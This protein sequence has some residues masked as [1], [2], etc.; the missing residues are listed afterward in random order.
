MPTF[1]CSYTLRLL[2]FLHHS[3]VVVCW[4][5]ANAVSLLVDTWTWEEHNSF[6]GR[7]KE[8]TGSL[9]DHSTNTM[10][11]T[12]AV[13]LFIFLCFLPGFGLWAAR[14]AWQVLCILFKLLIRCVTILTLPVDGSCTL[15]FT[16]AEVA[17]PSR[18]HLSLPSTLVRRGERETKLRS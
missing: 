1:L 10:Y 4:L 13:P 18:Q 14:C 3:K 7:K 15:I 12:L 11:G 5:A 17:V 16:L 6:V 9:R 8:F 2:G